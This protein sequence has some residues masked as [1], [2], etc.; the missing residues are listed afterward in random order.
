MYR[1]EKVVGM[2]REATAVDKTMR[3]MQQ[4]D[5]KSRDV[6]TILLKCHVMLLQLTQRTLTQH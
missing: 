6:L 5:C 1:F 3:Q 4:Q 2:S